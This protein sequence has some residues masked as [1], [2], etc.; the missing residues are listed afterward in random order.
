MKNQIKS[1]VVLGYINMIVNILVSLIYVPI[2]LRLMGQS[3]YGLYSLVASV[4]AYLSVLDMGFGNAMIRFVSKSKVRKDKEEEKKINGLFLLLYLIIGVVA[5]LIG[6]VLIF[7]V[8][9]IFKALTVAELAKAKIIM[10]ILVDLRS[11]FRKVHFF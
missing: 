2:M 4:I 6:L 1:G 5:F 10:A 7:N 9:N 3:E 8:S 11:R